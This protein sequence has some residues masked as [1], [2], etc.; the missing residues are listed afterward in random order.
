MSAKRANS[1]ALAFLFPTCHNLGMLTRSPLSFKVQCT[2]CYGIEIWKLERIVR[3]LSE[4][5]AAGV[6][7]KLPPDFDIEHIAEQFIAH[8]KRISCPGC[9]KTGT[10]DVYRILPP[11]MM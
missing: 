8:S 4:I 2:A 1:T 10:L 11:G 7:V 3:V 6:P 9:G 5:P